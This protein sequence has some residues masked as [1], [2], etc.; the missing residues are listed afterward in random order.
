MQGGQSG[1]SF[2]NAEH[3]HEYTEALHWSTT[4]SVRLKQDLHH[5]QVWL[6][7]LFQ[8]VCFVQVLFNMYH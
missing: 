8:R 3:H 4:V 6:S 7:W 5:V 1:K 2:M